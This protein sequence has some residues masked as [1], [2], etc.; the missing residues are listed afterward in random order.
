ML[1]ALHFSPWAP[2]CLVG[3]S[4]DNN[5]K[6]YETSWLADYIL[7]AMIEEIMG[8]PGD[9]LSVQRS[10]GV[11]EDPVGTPDPAPPSTGASTVVDDAHEVKN[12]REVTERA[13][14]ERV[15]DQAAAASALNEAA[16][17]AQLQQ[18]LGETEKLKAELTASREQLTQAQALAAAQQQAA[19]ANF[20]A[21]LTAASTR[22]EATRSPSRPS[23]HAATTASSSPPPTPLRPLAPT[24][25]A[26]PSSPLPTILRRSPPAATTASSPPPA[27]SPSCFA[28]LV[29]E[30]VARAAQSLESAASAADTV[31]APTASAPQAAGRFAPRRQQP[32]VLFKASG[33]LPHPAYEV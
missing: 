3:A 9:P 16:A 20:E 19:I 7:D 28:T 2:R 30:P 1:H 10:A 27:P 33:P 23:P 13:V 4:S 11:E 26:A 18:L 14:A 15:A 21:K 6:R 29:R 8:R 22:V 12:P 5:A 17:R 31:E 25:P 24:T 32:N